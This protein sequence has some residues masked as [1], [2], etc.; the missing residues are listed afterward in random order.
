MRYWTGWPSPGLCPELYRR[1]DLALPEPNLAWFAQG[2]LPENGADAQIE[3]MVDMTNRG[4]PVETA[5]GGV[6]FK[7]IGLYINNEKGQVLAVKIPATPGIPGSDVCGN[8]VPS[9]PGKD[10]LLHPG[11]NI[12]IVDG[13]KM[14]AATGGNLMVVGGKMTISPVLS[15]RAMS[16]NRQG[17]S[18]CRRSCYSG[19]VQEG[20]CQGRR[21]IRYCRH[22]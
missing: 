5:D 22:D 18:F 13:T 16:I 6:D 21:E 15:I 3:Y 10:V 14:V 8:S 19:T 17:I 7:N 1:V 9:R 11:S 20:F 4:K 2:K 12:Q